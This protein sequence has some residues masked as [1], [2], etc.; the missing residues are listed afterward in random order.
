MEVRSV[1]QQI[2]IEHRRRY[3]YR[4]ISAELRRRGVVVNHKRVARILREDNLLA[5]QPRQFVVTTKSD[6][7]LEVYLNLA[8][9]LKLT[10]MDQLWVADITYIRLKTEFSTWRYP[11]GFSR[12][13]RAGRRADRG[14]RSARAHDNKQSRRDSLLHVWSII[15]I[16]AFNMQS[17]AMSPF[18]KSMG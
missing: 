17:K 5:V 15:P 13:S 18:S 6:H 3:G 12:G 7:K 16:V 9:R 8:R 2:A 14:C 10:G 1:I 4:R 11:D